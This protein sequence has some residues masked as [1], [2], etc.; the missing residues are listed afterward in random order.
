MKTISSQ[1]HFQIMHRFH[2]FFSGLEFWPVIICGNPKGLHVGNMG[3]S[4]LSEVKHSGA[5]YLVT[6][7]PVLE[8]MTMSSISIYPKLQA[9]KVREIYAWTGPWNVP[10][11]R[12]PTIVYI[13]IF[14]SRRLWRL[15]AARRVYHAI[16][17]E[18]PC[19]NIEVVHNREFRKTLFVVF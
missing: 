1:D 3:K 17:V 6:V 15:E 14:F 19:V 12:T 8:T 7:I 18:R 13:Y 2:T 9:R 4:S 5:R 10:T 11:V 16:R